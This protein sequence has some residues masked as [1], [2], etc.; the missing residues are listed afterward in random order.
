[1]GQLCS[2]ETEDLRPKYRSDWQNSEPLGHTRTQT[3]EDDHGNPRPNSTNDILHLD[4]AEKPE[5]LTM[6]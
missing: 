6:V 4:K 2:K 5:A 3:E 1:M